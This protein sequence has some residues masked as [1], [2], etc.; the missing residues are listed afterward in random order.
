M[1]QPTRE[2]QANLVKQSYEALGLDR[3]L[4]RYFEAYCTGT[5]VGNPIEASAIS[6]AFSEFRTPKD[7]LY[8][9]AVKSSIGHL[10]GA[11]GIAGLLKTVMVLER[12]IIPPNMWFE[13]KNP[14]IL[15]EWNF[16]FPPSST[17]W[18]T[19]VIRR[20]SINS[21][22]YGGSNSTVIVDD[23]LH[24]LASNGLKGHHRTILHPKLP[25]FT[26]TDS[27]GEH[28]SNSLD[29]GDVMDCEIN[30]DQQ[31]KHPKGDLGGEKQP[32]AVNSHTNGHT[33]G[34][35]NGAEDSVTDGVKNG[36]VNGTN[37]E[38]SKPTS[39]QNG[40]AKHADL[41]RH[42][43]GKDRLF[44]LSAFDKGGIQRLATAYR[45]HLL[46]KVLS[47][48]STTGSASSHESESESYLSDL[49][50]TL[51]FKRTHFS[52]SSWAVADSMTSLARG[53]ETAQLNKAT[54][55]PNTGSGNSKPQLALVFAGKGA[56]WAGMGRELL[57]VYEPYRP[58]I[59]KA[60]EY[61]RK[62]LGCS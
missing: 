39:T 51:A 25:S 37:Q 3:G 46:N 19:E 45:E 28:L 17:V 10:E 42:H 62:T 55:A 52:W 22:D 34:T 26:I 9:G 57:A 61:L 15:D 30:G 16:K 58:S 18:P 38:H 5:P 40:R 12:G 31:T 24:F 35:R 36:F 44:I 11:A 47:F 27:E 29:G 21:F 6:D 56:Q 20:A 49:R 1:H 23:A 2:A 50:Y 43:L 13:K 7:P 33:K 53:L 4:A 48:S 60:D 32:S 8:I 41:D 14:R 59:S 54:R